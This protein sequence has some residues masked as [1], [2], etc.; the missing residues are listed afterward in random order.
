MIIHKHGTVLHAP[1]YGWDHGRGDTY[2]DRP[3]RVERI[4]SAL[5]QDGLARLMVPAED[6]DMQVIEAVHSPELIRYIRSS[7]NLPEGK[8][9]Y[10]YV[11]PYRK[12]MC[13]PDTD[14][15]EAGYYCFDVGTVMTRETF[16]S[17]KAAADTAMKGARSILDGKTDWAFAVSRPP[18][19]HADRDFYGGL[20]FF[21]NAAIAARFL[22]GHGPTAL[23]DLDFHHGNGSQGIFYDDAEVLYV[24][25]HGD[26]RHHFPFMTGHAHETGSG[27]GE[28]FTQNYPLPSGVDLA[29]YRAYLDR[30]FRRIQAFA[31]EFLVVSVGFDA[32][33]TDI[34]S[35]ANFKTEDYY[36]LGKTVRETGYPLL[37]CLEGGYDVEALGR[38]VSRFI[39]GLMD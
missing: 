16:R 10:P 15:H 17:A 20:C 11:F 9:V 25:I 6:C 24:S 29:Q 19:H 5:K 21:N 35:D 22:S 14:L 8:A 12:D 28:G 34:L 2:M 3:E 38:N 33:H 36:V 31:P 27:P 4:L 23:L 1:P 7:D 26:P 13:S 30:A 32:H 39:Q 18:G 37:A